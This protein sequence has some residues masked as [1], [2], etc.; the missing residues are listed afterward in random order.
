MPNALYKE[1]LLVWTAIREKE[2]DSWTPVVHI[3][4]K[5]SGLYQ[6][7]RFSGPS[8]LSQEAAINVA[9]KLAELWVDQKL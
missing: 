9:R 7:H 2:S 6:F 5:A 1:H 8:E 3:S 4:W